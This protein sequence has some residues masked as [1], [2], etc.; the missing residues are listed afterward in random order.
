MYAV[1]L[2]LIA[3]D[4]WRNVGVISYQI[5]RKIIFWKNISIW[6]KPDQ[7][8]KNTRLD[9][10]INYSVIFLSKPIENE[11]IHFQ[12]TMVLEN[13]IYLIISDTCTKSI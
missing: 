12:I 1:N 13:L 9:V 8:N 6:K 2:K 4:N 5:G 11:L 10:A 3:Q 7:N